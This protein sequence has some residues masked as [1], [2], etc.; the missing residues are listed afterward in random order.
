MKV[1]N[2]LTPS[3]GNVFADLGLANPA[4]LQLKSDLTILIRQAIQ[5]QALTQQQAAE[6]LGIQQPAVSDL[7]RGKRLEHYSLERLLGFLATLG[8]QVTLTIAAPQLEAAA[9]VSTYN[10]TASRDALQWQVQVD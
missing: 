6:N 10:L 2:T 3:S 5:D 8:H 9:S 1:N 7:V 4:E